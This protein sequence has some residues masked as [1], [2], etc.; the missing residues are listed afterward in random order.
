MPIRSTGLLD[1]LAGG[2]LM[3]RRVRVVVHYLSMTSLQHAQLKPERDDL[4]IIQAE[5][6]SPALNRFLYTAVG[7]AWYWMDR[8]N[9]RYSDWQRWLERPGTETWVAY[10]CGTPAGFY[11]LQPKDDARTMNIAYFGL[12]PQCV[13]QGFGGVLLSHAVRRAWHGQPEQVTVN[14]CSL[15]HP[16]ALANYQARGFRIDTETTETRYLPRRP[17]GP[18]PDADV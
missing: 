8:L 16:H 15:D 6:P 14:T 3:M 4:A 1:S 12:M 17:P 2:W 13:G 10:H 7:G 5:I 9:W 18:W 11:E